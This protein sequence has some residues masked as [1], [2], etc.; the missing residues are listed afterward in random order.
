MDGL[1]KNDL[2]IN[3]NLPFLFNNEIIEYDMKDAGFSLTKEY[4]LLPQE[5]IDKLEKYRKQQRTIEI[6]K[7]QRKNKTYT[8]QLKQAFQN[9]RELF[10]LSNGLE[11]PDIISV[12]KDAIFTRKRCANQQFGEFINFRPKNYYT[13]YINFGNNIEFY[14]N[15]YQLDIKGM[16]DEN[17]KLHEDYLIKFIKGFINRM[18]TRTIRSAF[19][20]YR[21]FLTKYKWKELE[22]GY[23]RTFDHRSV[24]EMED[25][26]A[27]FGDYYEDRVEDVDIKF[28]YF[29]LLLKFSYMS[30]KF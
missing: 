27:T 13:S 21:H 5:T 30:R 18:E 10:F 23:Y 6:G 7:I 2:F 25:E 1:W 29:T 24:Y 28:N 16:N 12:K 17:V 15:P 9:A 19:E 4:K 8:E 14:Y 3:K 26:D 22:L 11:K 20:Y